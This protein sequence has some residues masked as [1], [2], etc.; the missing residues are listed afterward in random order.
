[1]IYLFTAIYMI[2]GAAMFVIVIALGAHAKQQTARANAAQA[3]ADRL[4]EA[5]NVKH[6][7]KATTRATSG[8][9]GAGAGRGAKPANSATSILD[10]ADAIL[11][12]STGKPTGAR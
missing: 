3:E 8:A 11:R 2:G 10:Q 7:G 5:Y 4:R 1:M 9:D 12:G 6:S